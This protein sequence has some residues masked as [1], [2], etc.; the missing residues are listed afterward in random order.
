MAFT[1]YNKDYRTI[2]LSDCIASMY[3]DDLHELG[4]QNKFRWIGWVTDIPTIVEKL[5]EGQN[6]NN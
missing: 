6:I 1:S 2:V 5:E 4:L 3:G